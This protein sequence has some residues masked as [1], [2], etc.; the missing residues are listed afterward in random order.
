MGLDSIPCRSLDLVSLSHMRSLLYL[1]HRICMYMDALVHMLEHHKLGRRIPR[2]HCNL[3]DPA[4]PLVVDRASL[5]DY[6]LARGQSLWDWGPLFVYGA[7]LLELSRRLRKPSLYEMRWSKGWR[8][9]K[10]PHQRPT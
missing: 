5:P 4:I 6:L 7:V 1:H 2:R 8:A 3:A 9:G 10:Q